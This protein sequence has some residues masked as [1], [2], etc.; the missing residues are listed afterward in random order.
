MSIPNVLTSSINL[1]LPLHTQVPEPLV[2][3]AELQSILDAFRV[4]QIELDALKARCT[5]LEQYNIAHP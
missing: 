4:V 1:S 3:N 5:A 2:L